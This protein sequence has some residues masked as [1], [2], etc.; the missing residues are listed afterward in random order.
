MI[1]FLKRYEAA[2]AEGRVQAELPARVRRR[3]W[4]ILNEFNQPSIY[5]PDRYS[6]TCTVG[7]CIFFEVSFC[8]VSQERRLAKMRRRQLTPAEQ[9]QLEH[10]FKTTPDRRLRDRCQAV[11]M[12]SR[13]RKR[14]SIAQ[15]LGVH[16]TPVRLWLQHYQER[17]LEG[18]QSHWAPGQPR[19]MP[20]TLGA[21]LQAWVK[22][23]PVG[24]GL[25]RA[26]WPYEELATYVYQSTGLTVK[27]P[28]MRDLCQRHAIRPY[29]PTSRSW[30]GDPEEQRGAQEERAA[31]KKTR[32]AN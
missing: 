16:R 28:A 31:L 32:I 11:L 26:H 24:C 7:F 5:Y 22:A 4:Q 14:K 27:R 8:E 1:H 29:R 13:G 2:I 20:Q 12:A 3:L 21:T 15:D 6:N 23:G 10:F 17:G 19:R 18:V 30:R 25:D 9:A